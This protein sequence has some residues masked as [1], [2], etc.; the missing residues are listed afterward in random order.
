MHCF[1]RIN[2]QAVST[3]RIIIGQMNN[4]SLM[5]IAQPYYGEKFGRYGKTDGP[6]RLYCCTASRWILDQ[7]HTYDE[8]RDGTFLCTS[9][10]LVLIL[11]AW[12]VLL[13]PRRRTPDPFHTLV[14]FVERPN[15]HTQLSWGAFPRHKAP[16]TLCKKKIG[17]MD[18]WMD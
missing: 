17:I 5:L 3:K 12:L 13:K 2:T 6:S 1:I 8:E 4:R 15:I 9:F 14:G 10:L 16:G 18:E 7:T 11:F